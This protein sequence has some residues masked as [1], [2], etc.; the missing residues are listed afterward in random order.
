MSK[1]RNKIT[2][3][4]RKGNWLREAKQAERMRDLPVTIVY[5][6]DKGIGELPVHAD[7]WEEASPKPKYRSSWLYP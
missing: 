1:R 6:R 7:L 5:D 3:Y 2:K 4:N